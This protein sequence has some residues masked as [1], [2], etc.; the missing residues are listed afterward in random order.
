VPLFAKINT[1]DPAKGEKFELEPTEDFDFDQSLKVL[2]ETRQQEITTKFK[3][4]SDAFYLEAK[5]SVVA[6][7]AKVPYWVGVALVILGWN[8]FLAVITNPL[9][10]MV[11]AMVGV[12]MIAMWYLDML[13]LVETIAWK[14]YDQGYKLA[15]DKLKETMDKREGEKPQPQRQPQQYPPRY[16]SISKDEGDIELSSLDK[17]SQ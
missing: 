13:G 16:E 15:M 10:L 11:A 9:Y 3:R 6:T 2:S 12:P 5:R 1:L 17:K 14:V 7:Q 4:E 8:E